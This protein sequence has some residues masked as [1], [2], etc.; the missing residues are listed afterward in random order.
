M[1]RLNT[2]EGRKLLTVQ[3]MAR[4]LSMSSTWV[5]LQYYSGKIPGYKLGRALRFD[6]EEVFKALGL[7]S[8]EERKE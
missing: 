2:L 3:D 4:L 1:N 7:S 5:R 6:P 8:G